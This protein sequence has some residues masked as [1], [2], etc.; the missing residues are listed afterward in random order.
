MDVPLNFVN[1]FVRIIDGSRTQFAAVPLY[2]PT[3]ALCVP[4]KLPAI[5]KNKYVDDKRTSMNPTVDEIYGFCDIG[6]S[7]T[8]CSLIPVLWNIFFDFSVRIG[9]TVD[10]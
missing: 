9:H 5:D 4:L 7:S 8:V 10:P 1:N 3:G 6:N 2:L